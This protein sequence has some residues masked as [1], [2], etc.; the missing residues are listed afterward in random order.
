MHVCMHVCICMC[1]CMQTSAHAGVHLCD[2]CNVMWRGVGW[3]GV[4]YAS[5][6]ACAWAQCV[7]H[8]MHVCGVR[9]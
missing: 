3:C 1:T 5:K 9:V 2:A 8:G 4:V 6:Y 7:V